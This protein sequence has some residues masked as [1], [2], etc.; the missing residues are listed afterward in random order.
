MCIAKVLHNYVSCL[1]NFRNRC[2]ASLFWMTTS[3]SISACPAWSTGQ[4]VVRELKSCPTTDNSG[5]VLRNRPPKS[6]SIEHFYRSIFLMF[7]HVHVFVLLWLWCYPV[8]IG[9][10]WNDCV[11]LVRAARGVWVGGEGAGCAQTVRRIFVRERLPWTREAAAS[12]NV[13]LLEPPTRNGH[14]VPTVRVWVRFAQR[15]FLVFY[16]FLIIIFF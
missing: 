2:I 7:V 13:V 16:S 14:P 15:I 10:V 3:G 8:V 4:R 1:S 11:R 9:V 6:P 12:H 5:T